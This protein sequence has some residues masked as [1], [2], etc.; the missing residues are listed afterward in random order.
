MVYKCVML[1]GSGLGHRLE[2]VGIVAGTV[3]DSPTH[4]TAG[5]AVGDLNRQRLLVVY[6][7][8]ENLVCLFREIFKH[9]L[10]VEHLLC[11]IDFWAFGRNLDR[12]CFAV[13][14][15]LYYVKS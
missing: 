11:V 14:S 1:L 8:N 4:H 2:P 5:H 3:V 6:R 13:G 7:I 12:N 15:F 10:A 9:L